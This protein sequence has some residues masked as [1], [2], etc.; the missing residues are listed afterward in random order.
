[1]DH[2]DTS[3]TFDV[4]ARHIIIVDAAGEGYE[5]PRRKPLPKPSSAQ[6]QLVSFENHPRFEVCEPELHDTN[7]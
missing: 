2:D 7:E 5:G 6:V 4:P 1:M 3:T